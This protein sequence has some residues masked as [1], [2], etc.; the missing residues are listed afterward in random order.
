MKRF[1]IF[2]L[3]GVVLVLSARAWTTEHNITKGTVVIS[4][5]QDHSSWTPVAAFVVYPN[6]RTGSITVTRTCHGIEIPLYTGSFTKVANVS[7]VPNAEYPFD[8]GDSLTITSTV[9]TGIVQ[10]IRRAIP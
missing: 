5:D 6:R 9:P 8:T 3:I 7:W 1:L 4:N 10:I 2:I